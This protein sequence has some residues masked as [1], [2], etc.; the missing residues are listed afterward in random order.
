MTPQ[1][2]LLLKVPFRLTMARSQ[3][4]KESKESPASAGSLVSLM[5]FSSFSLASYT[6]QPSELRLSLPA[7]QSPPNEEG[8]R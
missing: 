2:K 1:E 5:V 4:E 6:T 3:S 8:T 7:I